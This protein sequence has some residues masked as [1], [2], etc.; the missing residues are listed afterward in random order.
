L[1]LALLANE[2]K[3]NASLDVFL[4]TIRNAPLF[5]I[6]PIS[7]EIVAEFGALQGFRDPADRAIVATARV[8]RLQLLTKDQNIIDSGLVSVIE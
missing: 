1:E 3:L 7:Y 4:N 5:S 6:L 2:R 8:H